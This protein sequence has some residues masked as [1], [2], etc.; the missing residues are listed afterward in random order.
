MDCK[1]FKRIIGISVLIFLIL[2]C[3]VNYHFDKAQRLE[4][5]GNLNE[6]ISKYQ[7]ITREYS[8]EPKAI[9]SKFRI[10]EINLNQFKSYDVAIKVY[11]EIIKSYSNSEY[12]EKSKVK[13]SEIENIRNKIKNLIQ[14]GDKFV[15]QKKYKDALGQYKKANEIDPLNESIN[16]KQKIKDSSDKLD[17]INKKQA[18]ALVKRK[19]ESLIRQEYPVYP[20]YYERMNFERIEWESKCEKDFIYNVTAKIYVLH[21]DGRAMNGAYAFRTEKIIQHKQRVFIIDMN[22]GKINE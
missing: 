17:E 13:L 2:G 1:L 6:A 10:A 4:K 18:I 11:E 12:A 3:G 20:S 9:E 8:K 5:E 7:E 22:T 19:Y 15:T 16:I 14:E 21:I